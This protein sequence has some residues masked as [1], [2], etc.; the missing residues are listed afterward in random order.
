MNILDKDDIKIAYNNSK[1]AIEK[2]EE[3]T[4]ELLLSILKKKESNII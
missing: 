1:K 4:N 2:G 3:S